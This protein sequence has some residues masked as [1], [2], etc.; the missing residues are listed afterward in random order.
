[1]GRE[2]ELIGRISRCGKVVDGLRDNEAF[3]IV[4]ED[5]RQSIEQADNTW[6]TLRQD[7]MD[8]FNDLRVIKLSAI[9]IVNVLESYEHDLEKAK[10]ELE[11][12]R[13]PDKIQTG[14]LDNE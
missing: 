10:E 3:N 11:A 13:N 5:F 14:Y 2:E 1:M 9:S 6:H 8:R 12:L 4:I 7:E